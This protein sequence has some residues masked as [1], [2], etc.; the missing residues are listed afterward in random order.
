[1]FKVQVPTEVNELT[2]SMCNYYC[3]T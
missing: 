1:V 3:L 2:L